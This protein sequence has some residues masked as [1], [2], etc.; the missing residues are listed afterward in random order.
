MACVGTD[1]PHLTPAPV[2][3]NGVEVLIL[4]PE[5]VLDQGAHSLSPRPPLCG[6]V[7]TQQGAHVRQGLPGGEGVALDLQQGDGPL[8]EAAVAVEDGVLAILPALIGQPGLGGAGIVDQAVAVAVAIIAHPARS[9]DQVGPQGADGLHVVGA[10]RVGAGQGDEE[11]GGVDP[12]VVEAE[13]HLAQGAHLAAACL[14]HD[15][16]GGGIHEGVDLCRLARGQIGQ[17]PL[18]QAGVDPQHLPGGDDAV[19]PER[20]REPGHAGVRIG[21][22]RQVGGQQ[23]HIRARL[24][25]PVIDAGIAG[26]LDAGSAP[27]PSAHGQA[28]LNGIPAPTLL[29]GGV[30]DVQSAFDIE[31]QLLALGQAEHELGPIG[32]QARR[33]FGKGQATGPQHL[34]QPGVAEA[35]PA[36]VHDRRMDLATRRPQGA[37]HLK[38]IGEV[39]AELERQRQQDVL[40]A[41]VDHPH[42]LEQ[43]FVPEEAPTFQMQHPG[44]GRAPAHRRQ[45]PVGRMAGEE[46]IVL[47]HAGTQPRRSRPSHGQD[48]VRQHPRVLIE[49]AVRAAFDVAPVVRHQKGVGVLERHQGLEAVLIAVVGGCSLDR[50]GVVHGLPRF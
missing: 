36:A 13:R 17:H 49:Q 43:P 44:R 14:V 12:A 9:G 21:A 34:I 8:R 6:A 42:P 4:H 3:G 50:I 45:G 18:G 31:I 48:E 7:I 41:V 24:P 30:A 47:G 25:Q 37:A 23:G 19:A 39:G 11:A 27:H 20:G 46:D 10:P 35:H 33:R 29:I 32:A 26:R 22:G 15:L 40:D 1:S 28:G 2:E 16:A 38:D 5:T